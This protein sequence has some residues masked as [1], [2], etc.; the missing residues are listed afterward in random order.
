LNSKSQFGFN[1]IGYISGNLG[2]A[3]TARSLI[4]ALMAKGNPVAVYDLDPGAGRGK[5]DNRFDHLA[6]SVPE[7]LPYPVNVFI[8]SPVMLARRLLKDGFSLLRPDRFNVA[9]P[10]WELT[11]L[12]EIVRKTLQMFDVLVAPSD[13][14][15]SV[16]ECNLP[17]AYVLS[18]DHPLSL[19]SGVH[20]KRSAFGLPE[21]KTVFVTSF[22]P[23]SD[24]QRKNPFAVVKAFRKA[25]QADPRAFLVIKLNNATHA[26]TAHSVI[27]ELEASCAGHHQIRLM[28]QSLSYPEVLSLYASC[29]AFVSLHR[30]EGLG[31]GL[32]E[33]MSLGKPVIATG[34]SGNMSFMNHTNSCLVSYKLI[35]VKGSIEAYANEYLGE[36]AVWA[37]PD[38]DEA[39]RWMQ[40]LASDQNLRSSI[41]KKAAADMS[42][43]QKKAKQVG[44]VDEIRAVWEQW[45]FENNRLE[46]KTKDLQWIREAISPREPAGIKRVRK[47]V[48]RL[49]NRYVLWRLR[50]SLEAGSAMD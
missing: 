25:F 28:T 30:S 38:V 26:G 22:D 47:D 48:K 41:G 18:A 31:L 27:K 46:Q 5:H 19:P 29:D 13:F 11:V 12:S 8:D 7:A 9:V 23:A 32:M 36:G 4:D 14:I 35:P 45:P 15:R 10:L 1:V 16:L 40:S 20:P 24:P 43:Y 34:W 49:L 3:V 44:F 2:L 21:D 37:E 50:K 17:D 39:A 6:V 42:G 33:A